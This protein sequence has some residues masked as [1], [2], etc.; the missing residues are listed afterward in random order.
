MKI[1]LMKWNP[2]N[3]S[4]SVRVWIT[5]VQQI[6]SIETKFLIHVTDRPQKLKVEQY[7]VGNANNK[8]RDRNTV[9]EVI[10]YKKHLWCS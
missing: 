10:V 1:F 7:K 2:Q 9:K 8:I 5:N 4:Y 3:F 6:H